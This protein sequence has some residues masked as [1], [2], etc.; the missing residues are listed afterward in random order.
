MK[1]FHVDTPEEARGKLL[2]AMEGRLRAEVLP[3]RRAVGRTLAEDVVSSLDV[4]GFARST[5]DGYAVVA[6]DTQGAGEAMPSFLEIVG[7]VRMGEGTELSLVSGQCAYVPTGAM[8]PAGADAV[9]MVEYCEPFDDRHVAVY[10][11]VSHGRNTVVRGEDISAGAVFLRRGTV[12][13]P[14]ELGALAAAGVEAVKVYA[15]LRLAVLSTGDELVQPGSPLSDGQIYDINTP[16]LTAL[17]ESRGF[18]V[19]SRT[20]LRDDADALRAAVRRAMEES[21]IVAVSGGSS[22]GKKDLTASI[23]DEVAVPGV[24]THG[25]ALK[26]GKPTILGY[27][28][29]SGK[30]LAGLPGHPVAAMMVFLL[31]I[32]GAADALMGRPEGF[33]IPA[34]MAVNVGCDAGKVNCIAVELMQTPRGTA[35]V[36]VYGKSGLIT[37][38]TRACGYI[39]TDQNCEG[40]KEGETAQVRLF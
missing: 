9:V 1:M 23:I 10:D 22:Q 11:A 31:L 28:A 27:D 4:P 25:L 3:V 30:I 17:A 13:G 12:I 24:F 2:K 29:R 8:L 6:A 21:D 40:L 33:S 19:T 35:A 16:A 32:A 15:P 34:V 36:P 7:E 37:T 38:L 5:V 14:R 39:L 20:V 26:P 18:L